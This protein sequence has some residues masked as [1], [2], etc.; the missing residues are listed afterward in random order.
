VLVEKVPPPADV[1]FQNVVE[2]RALANPLD[3]P[4]VAGALEQRLD[5]VERIGRAAA[6]DQA[7]TVHRVAGKKCAYASDELNSGVT[8]VIHAEVIRAA[9]RRP[10]D[11]PQILS[12]DAL[13][14]RRQISSL[15]PGLMRRRKVQEQVRWRRI[16]Q[17]EC[18]RRCRW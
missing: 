5:A 16:R 15:M 3:D 12:S 1:I 14:G 2:F 9:A 6:E 10:G 7:K 11:Q 4:L 18:R 8:P 13:A 17:F